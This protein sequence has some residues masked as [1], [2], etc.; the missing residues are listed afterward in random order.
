MPIGGGPGPGGIVALWGTECNDLL[1][2]PGAKPSKPKVWQPGGPP[3]GVGTVLNG[4]ATSGGLNAGGGPAVGKLVGKPVGKPIGGGDVIGPTRS[5]RE[6]CCWFSNGVCK[7]AAPTRASND[8]G[9]VPSVPGGAMMPS[10]E[11][12]VGA[13]CMGGGQSG[14]TPGGSKLGHKALEGVPGAFRYNPAGGGTPRDPGGAGGG[15]LS[16]GIPGGAPALAGKPGAPNPGCAPTGGRAGGSVNGAMDAVGVIINSDDIIADGGVP[17][18]GLVPRGKRPGLCEP[19]GVIGE[20]P[21]AIASSEINVGLHRLPS[22]LGFTSICLPV[23]GSTM[24]SLLLGVIG[25]CVGDSLGLWDGDLSPSSGRAGGGSAGGPDR[26]G[27]GEPSGESSGMASS[28]IS[29][30]GFFAR[31]GDEVSDEGEADGDALIAPGAAGAPLGDK[32][33]PPRPPV[34]VLGCFPFF[35]E[36]VGGAALSSSSDLKMSAK[37]SLEAQPNRHSEGFPSS[38]PRNLIRN[39]RPKQPPLKPTTGGDAAL[40]IGSVEL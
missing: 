17:T 21:S 32:G 22:G 24:A 19:A 3:E 37:V 25:V 5:T 6:R 31:N 27:V 14:A 36:G 28:K 35:A 1:G 20:R 7:L 29:C 2:V 40:A 26:L 16:I 8:M 18:G 33:A 39:S 10:R 15:T 30:G 38:R 34:G 4:P 12:G 11:T 9:A 23:S 13:A